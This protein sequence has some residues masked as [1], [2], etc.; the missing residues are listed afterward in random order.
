MSRAPTLGAVYCVYNEDE[1][2]EYSIRSILEVVDRVF[3]LLGEVPYRAYNPHAREQFQQ[4]DA[5]ESI[6]RRLVAGSPK[7]QLIKGRW[8]SELEHRNAGLALCRQAGMQYYFLV[9]GDEV[10]R[11]DHLEHLL[12]ELRQRP[13]VGQFIIKC[14]IF[15]RGFRFRIPANEMSWMPRRVFKLSWCSRLGKSPIPLPAP[16]R[17]IGNNKTNSWGGVHHLDPARVK[18]YH[19]S[20]ARLPQKMLEKLRTFS[21]AHEIP[22]DWYTRVWQAWPSHRSMTNLNPVDPPKFPR[23]VEAGVKDLPDVMTSHPY[24]GMEIIQ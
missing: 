20:Y 11:R 17:F 1:Y 12:T 13:A 3:V 22:T 8:D 18:F 9:D 2:I 21:H 24:Y 5:T 7:I 16:P 15:W 19:F 14:D 23:I 4:A 6:V 10:Y